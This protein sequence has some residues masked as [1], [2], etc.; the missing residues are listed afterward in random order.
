MLLPGW[1]QNK[2][3]SP[4]CD[5]FDF[6]EF[7][8]F[9]VMGI[10]CPVTLTVNLVL[11][12]LFWVKKLR[13][14]MLYLLFSLFL[15]PAGAETSVEFNNIREAKGNLYIA[16]FDRKDTFW[17]PDQAGVK[18]IVPVSAT[19][20]MRVSLG[21]LP[22]GEYA[23]SCFHDVN[24]N[25]KLDTN[26]L[27]IPSEPYGFSN[28]ARPKFRAPYWSEAIFRLEGYARVLAIRLDTW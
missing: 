7:L 22:A 19:G 17:S 11:W 6:F 1:F 9:E 18:K 14:P 24:G 26:L 27:G 28:N 15:L 8:I 5:S 2:I 3:F 10:F 12:M 4:G 25:G 23:L 13:Y 20:S 16:V 21:V